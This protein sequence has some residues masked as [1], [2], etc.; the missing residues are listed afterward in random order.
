VRPDDKRWP[1][2]VYS[3]VLVPVVGQP[4]VVLWISFLYFR[5]RRAWPEAAK[6]INLHAWIAV[7]MNIVVTLWLLRLLRR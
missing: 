4:L 7:A 2:I 1:W 5:W 6:R 3:T